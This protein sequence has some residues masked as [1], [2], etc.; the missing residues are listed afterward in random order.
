MYGEGTFCTDEAVATERDKKSV[1][2]KGTVTQGR[3][4]QRDRDREIGSCHKKCES[5]ICFEMPQTTKSL[6]Y[7]LSSQISLPPLCEGGVESSP[8]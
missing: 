3:K 5:T 8:A 1:K 2:Y 4:R 7:P 6:Y